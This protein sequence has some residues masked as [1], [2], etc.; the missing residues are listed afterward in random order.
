MTRLVPRPLPCLLF[1]LSACSGGVAT[2]RDAGPAAVDARVGV[3]AEAPDA[4]PEDAGEPVDAFVPPTCEVVA[5][6]EALVLDGVDD[7]VTASRDGLGLRELTVEAWVRRDG[8]GLAAGTGA[9]GVSVVPI[10]GKGRGED[11]GSNIDC[12]YAFGFAGEVLAAD[13]EDLASGAN[14]PVIGR[15]GVPRGEWHHVAV[16]YDGAEWRLYLDGTEDGRATA[17][18]TPRDDSIQPFGI[19]TLFNSTAVAAGRLDGAL[20]ELRVWDHARSADEIAEARFTRV[21]TAEGL[22]GRWAFEGDGADTTGGNDATLDGAVFDASGPMLDLGLPPSVIDAS[23]ADEATVDATTEITLEVS[24]V[25]GDWLDVEVYVRELTEVDDFTIAVLPDTQYYTVESRGLERYFH[26]QTR[27]IVDHRADYRIAAVIHNGDIV[28]NGDRLEY[29][30]RVADRAM[31]RLE[32]IEGLVDGLPFGVAVG[33]HDLSVVSQVGPARLFNEYFG[34]ERFLGRAYYGG[35]RVRTDNNDSWFTFEAGGLDFVVVS[36]TY[37]P[38]PSQAML[39]FA[40]RVFETHPDAFG[41]LNAHYILTGAGN[42]SAQGRAMYDALRDVPNLHLMTCGHV[43]AEARRTDT[44]EG[45][46]ILSMLADYQGRTDGGSGYMRLWE[47]S[48]ANG[49][50]TVRTYSPT[51]DRWETD[52]NS[53]FTVAMALRG[54]GTGAFEHVG[55][56]ED[57]VDGAAS[58]RVEG[59]APGRIYEWYAAVRD[60]E[61]ETRTPVRRFTTAVAP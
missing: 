24:D 54:A 21:E 34:R 3:D 35:S 43:S 14:H 40:R 10:A 2:E 33:N 29:Q 46:P 41:I 18:A 23:P 52:A 51:L 6:P 1:A 22:V 49:E 38:E 5:P 45:H 30:W 39:D 12:N 60:C 61:H 57:V 37:N 32:T 48:P 9:G 44:H 59:L 16:T 20:A 26:D 8:D 13:F 11:D 15:T 17:N 19:G 28:N 42:F 50:M 27:W 56:V 53:E 36:L 31:A 25:D 58:V 7:G 4:G 55:T 47:L